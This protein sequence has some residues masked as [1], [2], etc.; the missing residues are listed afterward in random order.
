[1]TGAAPALD[2]TVLR[3]EAQAKVNLALSVTGTR[4][5]GYHELRSVFLRL[6][7]ADTITL[8]GPAGPDAGPEAASDELVIEGDPDCPVADNLVLRATEGFRRLASDAGVAVPAV[9]LQLAKR[10]P[11][12]AGLAGEPA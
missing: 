9:R 7:L 3:L 6:E 11:I 5:D 10:I 1:M 8:A 12:A 4:P 2:A